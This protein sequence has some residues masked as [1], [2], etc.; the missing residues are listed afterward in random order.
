MVMFF[1]HKTRGTG[2]LP[3]IQLDFVLNNSLNPGI[4]TLVHHLPTN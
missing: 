3:T 2:I 1:N 4:K